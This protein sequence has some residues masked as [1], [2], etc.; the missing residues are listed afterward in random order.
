MSSSLAYRAP[1]FAD[2]KPEH[3]APGPTRERLAHLEEHGFVIIDDFAGSPW[4]A[5]LREAG[6]RLTAACAPGVG[7]DR[8][9]LDY[10][11]KAGVVVTNTPGVMAPAV[12]DLT[13]ALLLSMVLLI[14]SKHYDNFYNL[15]KI[16]FFF[17]LF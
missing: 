17:Y 15:V 8:I 14:I 2:F 7:Y 16:F 6:R 10:W 11:T 13:F 4:I 3:A 5:R 9:D 1:A 12:A